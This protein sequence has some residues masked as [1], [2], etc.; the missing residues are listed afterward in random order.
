VGIVSDI[1]R[2]ESV[3]QDK[4]DEIVSKVRMCLREIEESEER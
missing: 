1:V 2:R 4:L 3:P